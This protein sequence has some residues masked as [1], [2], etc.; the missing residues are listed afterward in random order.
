MARERLFG[1]IGAWLNNE[2]LLGHSAQRLNCEWVTDYRHF[3]LVQI[4]EEHE[5]L[6]GINPFQI[7]IPA[8]IRPLTFEKNGFYL[9]AADSDALKS[10]DKLEVLDQLWQRE[11]IHK[12]TLFFVP[13]SNLAKDATDEALARLEADFRELLGQAGII[14]R[15]SV[16][17][18]KD[19]LP[20]LP[21]TEC[22]APDA[23]ARWCFE[24]AG[25]L[26]RDYDAEMA[27]IAHRFIAARASAWVRAAPGNPMVEINALWGLPDALQYC[28]YDIW[29][30]HVP[31]GV[32]TD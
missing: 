24:M 2:L 1:T 25:K 13:V 20:N 29:E 19:K 8:I 23:A 15:T 32:A 9:R 6:S 16:R 10:W 14:V 18:G 17:A 28:P 11:S 12:P 26:S 30:V 7:R 21:R 31:T 4:D 22:L 3:Y 5:D 27:F